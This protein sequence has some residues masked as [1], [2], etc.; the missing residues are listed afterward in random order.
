M[1]E[2][3]HALGINWSALLAQAINFAILI[4]ILA[5]FV[6]KPVLAIIDRRRDEIAASMEKVKEIDRQKEII[7][8]QRTAILRKADVEAG[9]LLARAKI[10]AE[11]L[12]GELLKSAKDQAARTLA[13][14]MEQL[15]NERA[16]M[17]KEIQDKL[18]HAIVKSAE[19]ILR[20][21]FSKEDQENFE[22]ELKK[23]L[24]A[25]LA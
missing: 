6:Y 19:T 8:E 1:N 22:E 17:V 21:E 5:K 13:K 9:E 16:H 3:I 14:G 25:M 2:I 7:D 24:P 18:A 23:N 15:E 12:Q 4:F 11:A 10:D 20:R